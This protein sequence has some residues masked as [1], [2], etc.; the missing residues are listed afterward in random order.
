MLEV[1]TETS[2]AGQ[3]RR[4]QGLHRVVCL[5]DRLDEQALTSQVAYREQ[6]QEAD[7]HDEHIEQPH[8]VQ[9]A[10]AKPATRAGALAQQ[11]GALANHFRTRRKTKQ[12]ALG[13]SWYMAP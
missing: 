9:A 11:R 3:Q 6:E 8:L 5:R 2:V 1:P 13:S 12:V 4:E 10:A 7:A